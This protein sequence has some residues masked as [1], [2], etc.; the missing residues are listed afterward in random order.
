M[1]DASTSNGTRCQ[2]SAR[3]SPELRDRV[4]VAATQKGLSHQEVVARALTAYLAEDDAQH[5]AIRVEN[6]R[7]A[8]RIYSGVRLQGQV[9]IHTEPTSTNNLIGDDLLGDNVMEAV[10]V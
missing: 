3:V 8:L 6:D 5:L 4:R 9:E 7:L 1:D 10:G 2:V